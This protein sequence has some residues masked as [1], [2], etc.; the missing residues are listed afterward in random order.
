MKT[1]TTVIAVLLSILTYAGTPAY[2]QAMKAALGQ[3]ST[4]KSVDELQATAN[5]FQRISK[6]A[7]QE[8][9]PEYYQAHCYILMSFSITDNTQ[10]DAYLDIAETAITNILERQPMNSEALALQAFMYTGRLVIDPMT[11]GREFSIKSNESLKK[12]LSIN[13]QN[14]RALYLQLTNEIG[15]ADFFGT[16][17]AIYCERIKSLQKNWDTYNQVQDL[18][19]SWGKNQ[20]QSLKANCND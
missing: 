10:K 19:P 20:A 4:S 16:D 7:D 14:P 11:R 5:S 15:M 13:P 18:E 8:W 17:S 3:F 12:S 6:I 9:L 2:N 1:I